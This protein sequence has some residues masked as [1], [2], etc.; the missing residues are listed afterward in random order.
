MNSVKYSNFII[1]TINSNI[2]ID[3]FYKQDYNVYSIDNIYM[4]TIY[5]IF[6]SPLQRDFVVVIQK[7]VLPPLSLILKR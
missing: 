3:N 7:S 6:V 1:R 5:R 2:T 4:F